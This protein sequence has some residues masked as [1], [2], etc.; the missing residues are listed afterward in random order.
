M[1][2]WCLTAYRVARDVAEGSMSG[3][4][5]KLPPPEDPR[6]VRAQQHRRQTAGWS[7]RRFSTLMKCVPGS[8]ARVTA[9]PVQPQTL[10]RCA[11]LEAHHAPGA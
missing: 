8:P 10:R 6:G 7:E 4:I 3:N 11:S 1:R 9:M 5:I 2:I